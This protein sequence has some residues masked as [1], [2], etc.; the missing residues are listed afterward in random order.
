MNLEFNFKFDSSVLKK[1][2]Q[3]SSIFI[4]DC[5]A[6]KVMLKTY[7]LA[8]KCSDGVTH[9]SPNLE[10]FRRNSAYDSFVVLTFQ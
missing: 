5:I 2:Y 4:N 9:W 6:P 7:R 3:F 1:N 8:T 10:P